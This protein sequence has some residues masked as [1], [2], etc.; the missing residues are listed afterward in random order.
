MNQPIT[1]KQLGI[2]II[3]V[4]LGGDLLLLVIGRLGVGA[5]GGIGPV[6]RML[7]LAGLGVAL[8]GL[9]M[10]R[11]GTMPAA[12]REAPHHTIVDA[13]FAPVA[14]PTHPWLW[15]GRGLAL[16]ALLA[17]LFYLGVYIVY[18]IDL[19][20]WPYDYDQ[21]ES[22]E[23]YD[24]IL[25]SQGKWPYRDA[26]VYPFYASNYPPV[27]HLLTLLF[28]PLLGQRL[29]AG[30]ILSFIISLLT[31]AAIGWT[32][33]R[34]VGGIFIPLLS[35]LAYTASNFV[36]HIGPLCR[37]HLTMIL[38]E[39]LAV[40][41]IAGTEDEKHGMRNTLLGLGFL[42]I[43]GYTKQLSVFTAAAIFGYLFLRSPQRAIGFV[44]IFG[45]LFVWVFLAINWVT[46]GQWWLNTI[47]AN[48]NEFMFPQLI[49]LVKSWFKIHTLFVLL[50]LGYTFYEAYFGQFSVYSL[51]FVCVLGT[52]LMSGKWG[53]GEA[54]WISSV[55]AAIIL[56]GFTVGKVRDWLV[57]NRPQWSQT[58]VVL[59]PLLFL[60]QSTRM[61]HLPTSGPLFGTLARVLGVAGHSAYADYPY[62]DA[63]G[64]S[65]VGHLMLPRDHE[66]GAKIM[67]YVRST[68]KP[69]FS[70][71]AAFT[72]LGGKPVV[73][74]PTQL[75]NLYNNGLL[76]ITELE[77]MIRREDFGLV[78]MRAQFYPP[79]ILA[80]IGQHYG[81]VEHIPMNGFNYII[82]QP[83]GRSE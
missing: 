49:A 11:Q 56:S 69:V 80:A 5:W 66:G 43:A 52:G 63:V 9:P 12:A 40:F 10:L 2:F 38:L 79:P 47:S 62:Y 23:L 57:D 50:A 64:Y 7:L 73:T 3:V 26:D 70:E 21:G 41:F 20:H 76:D 27:F 16:L 39:T 60:V 32:V 22:F 24:A 30:R 36:Y 58:F 42:F 77:A 37:Q 55:A 45:A 4:G 25:H 65:Q 6:E 68:D 1:K 31:A 34:R 13:W 81:L 44:M 8:M 18:A 28:F 48:V 14:D 15:I 54:Y 74:N 51:W 78:I 83:L 72:M 19:F 61:L 17:F 46:D 29:L 67:D 35:A 71:E 59:V 33:R 75:L 82:M 53:A